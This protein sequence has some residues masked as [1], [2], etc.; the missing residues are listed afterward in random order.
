MKS[1]SL[2]GILLIFT[3]QL[4]SQVPVT[5]TV[6]DGASGE[7]L[8]GATVS[9]EGTTTGTI[10]G[11]NGE[12]SIS[13][14]SD[15]DVLVVSF[16]GFETQRIPIGTQRSFGVALNMDVA[17]LEE[18]VVTALGI[19][20]E[21]K[22]LGY[23]VQD[24]DSEDL[25]KGGD[26]N[27]VSAL[28]GKIAGVQIT[29][30]SGSVGG[31]AVIKIRGNKSF[32]GNTS[33]LFV[34][35]GVPI[36]NTTSTTD[37]DYGNAAADIDPESIETMSVLKGAN[38]TALYGSRGANGVILITTKKG[39]KRK[40]IGVTF[41][42]SVAFDEVY[43]LPNYQNEYGQGGYGSEYEYAQ[44]GSTDTYQEWA[45]SKWSWS[46]DDTWD[47]SFGA[48]LDN[49]VTTV[50]FDS[51]LNGDGTREAT[52]MISRPDN[53]K[54][55]YET[56][57]STVNSVALSGGGETAQGRLTITHTNQAG[58]TPNTD[59]EKLNIGFN[60]NVQLIEKLKFEI[61]G[62]YN[63]TKN[64][65]LSFQG[66]STKNPLYEFN[67]WFGRQVDVDY[68]KDHYLDYVT[69]EDGHLSRLNWMTGYSDYNNNIYWSLNQNLNSRERSRLFGSIGTTYTIAD[70][71]ELVARVG[72]D[73]INEGRISNIHSDTKGSLDGMQ[74][75]PVNGSFSE[76]IYRENE[77]NADLMLIINR[78]LTD[79]ITINSTI[80]A[81]YRRSLV[82]RMYIGVPNLVVPDFYSTSA[83]DG[84]IIGSK[85]RW[86]KETNSLF[87]SANF[88]Y[89]SFLFMDLTYRQDWSSTLPA[90]SRSYGYPSATLGFIFSDAFDLKNDLFSYGKV[91][92]SYAEVGNDTSPYSIM[93]YYYKYGS[94][95]WSNGTVGDAN[96][97][98]LGSVLPSTNL[99]PE[100]TSSFE[101]GGEFKFFQNR[102][103]LDAAYYQATTKNQLM[104]VRLAP[105]TG[106]YTWKKNAGTMQNNGVEI[107]IY[108]TPVETDDFSWDIAVN[109]AKNRNK[110]VE[111]DGEI[112]ELELN[113]FSSAKGYGVTM[114][115]REGEEWGTLEGRVRETDENGNYIV[116]YIEVIDEIT[117]DVTSGDYQYVLTDDP[118]KVGSVN[119]DFIG[120]V[121][122]TFNYKGFSL[123]AL[124]DVR[125]GGNVYS[126]TKV[127]GQRTGILQATVDNDQRINGYHLTGVFADGVNIGGEDVS[128]QESDIVVTPR[129]FWKYS[130][131][132]TE[133]GIIDGSFIK[134]REMNFSY[135]FPGSFV[136][137]L[138]LQSATFSLFA[139]NVAL[140]YTHKSNDVGIDPEV[141]ASGSVLDTGFENFNLPPARTIGAKIN[142]NF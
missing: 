87:A 13:A 4:Y 49:G 57:I 83:A 110:I 16:I 37:I 91:R 50:Q 9:I 112:K 111:L 84:N 101:F 85:N 47:E 56:G 69:H 96:F 120:G 42:S 124:V 55:F 141:A 33:P 2:V 142:I 7:P 94:L 3:L 39:T 121:R 41:S 15:A 17:E 98:R 28:S 18:V 134:L 119:P 48:R 99:I 126:A 63:I 62:N 59:Q 125:M 89:R 23:S 100:R 116:E 129:T 5:G 86:E 136:S 88:G 10:T 107:Q 32:K 95:P 60:T 22:A 27:V 118:V 1:F 103:G 104:N 74:Q 11:M 24:I 53:V 67:N 30:A 64:D 36:S 43:I 114:W 75:N 72:T 34:V 82:E 20:R 40:G 21:K 132:Y 14:A 127:Q 137:K 54:N 108:A 31:S 8:P 38:A 105:S 117:G 12:F 29:S 77:T 73:D 139:R 58:T 122:N 138:H 76:S 92:A 130:R 6:T 52:E 44:S 25:T 68:L 102:L 90:E 109:Y 78:N 123:S 115:A 93:P 133:M 140:L 65:N 81:N 45:A 71:F 66:R 128:G 106:Y 135:R 61:N 131:G 51:P 113:G 26:N 35:D 70:G 79:H 19:K 97:F 80:G 46:P